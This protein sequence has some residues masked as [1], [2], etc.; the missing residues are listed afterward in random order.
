MI[1]WNLY[2]YKKAMLQSTEFRFVKTAM[3]LRA[4]IITSRHLCREVA[5]H[6]I[7]DDK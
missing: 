6:C 5:E 7:I 4:Q 3:E 1:I 2:P